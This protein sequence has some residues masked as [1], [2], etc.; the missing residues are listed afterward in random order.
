MR[1][2]G[3]EEVETYILRRQNTVTHYITAWTVLELCLEVGQWPGARVLMRWW[4]KAGIDLGQGMMRME[5][6]TEE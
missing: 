6:D 4:N 1:E 2:V 3:M 5:M